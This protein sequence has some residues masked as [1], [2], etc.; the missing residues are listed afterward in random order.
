MNPDKWTRGTKKN[1]PQN[2]P[3]YIYGRQFLTSTP[4]PHNRE[5]SIHL[6]KCKI[7]WISTC[8]R[9]KLEPYPHQTKSSVCQRIQS[10]EWK[11]NQWEIDVRKR[12]LRI[13][14]C[15]IMID[16]LF[17][18]HDG[19]NTLC[20]QCLSVNFPLHSQSWRFWSQRLSHLTSKEL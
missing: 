9:I 14:N 5:R 19:I 12:I 1:D 11:C 4:R 7:T 16:F 13:S 2:T 17:N 18:V 6:T 15:R 10:T 3:A 8:K 20:H